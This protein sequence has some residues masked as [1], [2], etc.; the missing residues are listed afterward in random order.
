MVLAERRWAEQAG[1]GEV[2]FQGPVGPVNASGQITKRQ[3]YVPL[4][5]G[6]APADSDLPLVKHP[7]PLGS[8]LHR[9]EQTRRS[10]HIERA[11][12][13]DD[14]QPEATNQARGRL[15]IGPLDAQSLSMSVSACGE[16]GEPGDI[17]F[18]GEPTGP[19]VQKGRECLPY[20]G[21]S[22]GL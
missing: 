18:V 15:R 19:F 2:Q 13:A 6:V 14:L 8:V 9:Y 21:C 20:K 5:H 17:H 1:I 3:R 22:R 4:G 11:V 10:A 12:A 16:T 7:G